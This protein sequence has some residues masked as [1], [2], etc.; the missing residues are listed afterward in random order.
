M[1]KNEKKRSFCRDVGKPGESRDRWWKFSLSSSKRNFQLAK[2]T[3]NILPSY[4]LDS[5]TAAGEAVWSVMYVCLR[6]ILTRKRS[7][8]FWQ[9]NR[10]AR[11]VAQNVLDSERRYEWSKDEGWDS[12]S[13]IYVM[14]ND[15]YTPSTNI[16]ILPFTIYIPN[17]R[18][19]T[20]P[21]PIPNVSSAI[22]IN[23]LSSHTQH[24]SI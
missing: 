20:L 19:F 14:E 2:Q 22:Q 6:K 1:V 15:N 8:S 9:T 7:K 10:E 17:R 18:V 21:S 24:S 11:V 3:Q 4:V 13:F 5:C 23:F 16:Q 12:D